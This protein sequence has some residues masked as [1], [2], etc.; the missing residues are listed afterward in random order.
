MAEIYESP[1]GGKTVY[2]REIGSS[3]RQLIKEDH[4]T[5]ERIREDQLW[6]EI[7]QAALTN[8]TIQDALE[9]V[10]I[11]YYISNEYEKRYGR[12]T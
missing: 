11:I 9:R 3:D 12:K 8:P 2:K 5:I 6:K 10:K 1:D 4:L 7:R